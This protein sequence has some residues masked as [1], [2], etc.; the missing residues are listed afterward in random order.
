MANLEDLR[1]FG[2]NVDEGLNRCVNNEEFYLKMIRKAVDDTS[3]EEL[4]HAVN[5]KDMDQAFEI[6]HA[7]KGVLANLALTPLCDPVSEAVELL[8]N[9][10]DTDYSGY[11]EKIRIKREELQKL[12]Q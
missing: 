12:L 6:A 1:A 4:D 5:A 10:T 9:R 7:L 11:L 3:F 8:R 2:A